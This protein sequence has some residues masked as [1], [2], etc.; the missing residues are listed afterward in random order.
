VQS[1]VVDI[2]EHSNIGNQS[3]CSVDRLHDDNAEKCLL[4]ECLFFSG[5]RGEKKNRKFGHR[6]VC[7]KKDPKT[8]KGPTK[9]Q[10]KEEK[11]KMVIANCSRK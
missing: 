8:V 4:T 3:L 2:L 11:V 7:V 6:R 9:K 1:C 10:E 5:D